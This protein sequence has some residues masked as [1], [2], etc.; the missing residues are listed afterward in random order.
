M[1]V[2]SLPFIP[3]FY[4]CVTAPEASTI[5]LVPPKK[6]V[7]L[8]SALACLFAYLTPHNSKIYGQ[9]LL[10]FPEDLYIITINN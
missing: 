10:K 7:V 5:S 1:Y 2:V 8:S 3:L 9:I 4:L 6:Q